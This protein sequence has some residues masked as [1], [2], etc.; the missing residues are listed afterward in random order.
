M[1]AVGRSWWDVRSGVGPESVSREVPSVS[2]RL[3]RYVPGDG[4]REVRR[5]KTLIPLVPFPSSFS[6][7]SPQF[8]TWR[9]RTRM[10][11]FLSRL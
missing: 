6:S 2:F 8:F 3:S 4:G 1:S 11:S 7:P 10:L 9:Q 5:R